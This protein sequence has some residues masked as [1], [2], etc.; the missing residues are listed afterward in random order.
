MSERKVLNKSGLWRPK[1]RRYIGPS[2]GD[3]SHKMCKAGVAETFTVSIALDLQVTDC[4][5]INVA[6]T[7]PKL[8]EN[9]Q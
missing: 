2:I 8:I 6:A 4:G 9:I 3:C 1:G 7:W 5:D